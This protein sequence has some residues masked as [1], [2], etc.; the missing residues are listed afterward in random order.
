MEEGAGN[1]TTLVETAGLG[2]TLAGEDTGQRLAPEGGGWRGARM[3]WEDKA[4]LSVQEGRGA[5]GGGAL[6]RVMGLKVSLCQRMFTLPRS[7]EAICALR[8][9][10]FIVRAVGSPWWILGSGLNDRC[11]VVS[12]YLDSV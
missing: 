10:H 3:L 12:F 9:F 2:G 5:S 4:Q 1:C 8:T 11:S 6:Y 7:A